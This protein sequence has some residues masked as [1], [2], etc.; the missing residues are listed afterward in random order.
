MRNDAIVIGGSFAGLSAAMQL[1][2]A[3]RSVCVLDTGKPRNRFALASHG[4][5]GQDG[6][7]P[8]EML[9]AAREKLAAYPSVRFIDNEAMEAEADDGG[10]AIRL[11][12]GDRLEA[13]KLVLAFG[14]K[15]SLPEIPGIQER[16]GKTVLHCPY[17]HGFEFLGQPLGV[18]SVLP[19]STHQAQLIPE[20][21]PTTFFL[22]GGTMPDEE[23][24]ARLAARQVTIEAAPI[25]GLE[26]EAPDLQGVRLSD[27][28]LV[29][30][31][32]LYLAPRTSFQSPIA[33]QL[34]C[35]LEDGPTGPV[36]K[37]DP[38]K[39]TSI[40]GVF[41]AGD[42]TRPMHNATLASA[43]GVMA[44]GAVHQSLVFG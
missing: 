23:T 41:A 20:W 22:N 8:Y 19:H 15:D 2:R 33:D 24:C 39:R 34:G 18:L 38:M 1:A 44:G 32:A 4:F 10:F 7:A 5:F 12:D 37:T 29:T 25:V 3:N 11:A 31:A 13:R 14:L 9:K 16:W 28:R 42:I 27:G 30:I 40:A 6:V 36:I 35:A 21:G 26:G 43:D 17:C